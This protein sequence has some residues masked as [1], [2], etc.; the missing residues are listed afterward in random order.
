MKKQILTFLASLLI[1]SGIHSQAPEAINYQAVVRDGAGAIVANQNVGIQLSVL[2]GS[3]TGTAVYQETFTPTTNTFGLV[4]MQIGN[5]AVQTGTFNT[6][7]WGNGPYFIETAVD[8]TGGT[9]YVSIS[10]TQFMSVPYALHAKTVDTTFLN[11][12]INSVSTDN[13]NLKKNI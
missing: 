13:Q 4:N 3:A 8:I 12:V 9:N 7:V 2:Q 11:N 6:I 5:G 10:T 1:C